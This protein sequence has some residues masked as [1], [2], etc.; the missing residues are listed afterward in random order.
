MMFEYKP[1]PIETTITHLRMDEHTSHAHTRPSNINAALMR[2]ENPPLH[3]YRYLQHSVGEQHV[4]VARLR[5]TDDELSK[6]IHA[7]TTD[8]DVL[9]IDGVPSGFYEI[10]RSKPEFVD[11][12]YFGLM[13]HAIGRGLGKW[14]LSQAISSAWASEPDAVSVCTCTLD[15]PAA[16]G[17]YQKLGFKA[18]AQQH[19]KYAPLS[20]KERLAILK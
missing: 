3:F 17:L 16:L 12:A 6:I 2:A 9:Y 10:D 19:S 11:L 18:I 1:K 7:K 15:H 14:F 5:M 4:W 8:I 13:E 20:K